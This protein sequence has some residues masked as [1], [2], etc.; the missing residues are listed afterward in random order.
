MSAQNI[1]DTAPLGAL[2]RYSDGAPMPPARFNKKVAAWKRDNGVGRLVRKTPSLVMGRYVAPATL[3][4]HEGNFASADVIVLT[5]HR[6]FNL[7]ENLTFEVVSTPRPRTCRVLQP[8]GESVELIHLA[9]DRAAAEAWL[10]ENPEPHARLEEVCASESEF[11]SDQTVAET[12]TP[13][14]REVL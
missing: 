10:R 8:F 1:Y 7:T 4:L 13:S 6:C 3:T 11:S 14:A 9:R 2:I 5:V 12:M